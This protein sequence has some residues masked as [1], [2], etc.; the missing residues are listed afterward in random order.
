[1]FVVLDQVGAWKAG[2]EL[3]DNFF[4]LIA[5]EPGVDDL[6]LLAQDRIQH[7]IG[8][9]LAIAVARLLLVVEVN[10][11]PTK[12]RKLNEQ[13]FFDVVALVEF[14]MQW[15]F[16]PVHVGQLYA[17]SLSLCCYLENIIG[18]CPRNNISDG[19]LNNQHVMVL[20]LAVWTLLNN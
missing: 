7:D 1:M 6:E 10:N 5:F 13:R 2:G 12:A 9:A 11:L 15:Y 20:H 8:E 4:D 16:I 17:V 14:D 3:L 19:L 18:T